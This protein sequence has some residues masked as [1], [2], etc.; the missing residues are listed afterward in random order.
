MI[1]TPIPFFRQ[2]SNN[3]ASYRQREPQFSRHLPRSPQPA[4]GC[5]SLQLSPGAVDFRGSSSPPARAPGRRRRRLLPA[6]LPRGEPQ[7]ANPTNLTVSVCKITHEG[8][9]C[10]PAPPP[11]AP[12]RPAGTTKC[13][14]PLPGPARRNAGWGG[15]VF[16]LAQGKDLGHLQ[17]H[18]GSSP[19]RRC[20]FTKLAARE[21]KI[22]FRTEEEQPLG[23]NTESRSAQNTNTATAKKSRHLPAP[24]GCPGK[25]PGVPAH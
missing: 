6:L 18:V 24:P 3:T 4:A 8:L 15:L 10:A 11:P 17:P 23:A 7:V 21:N 16:P 19:A 25:V 1:A 13:P 14:S 5:P 20:H 2:S 12:G 9:P 22:K